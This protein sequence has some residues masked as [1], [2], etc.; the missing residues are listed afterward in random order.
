MKSRIGLLNLILWKQYLHKHRLWLLMV[1]LAAFALRIWNM[2]M[3]ENELTGILIG[4]Y[5][6]DEAGARL[7]AGLQE[8]KAQGKTVG[9]VFRFLDYSDQ[10]TMLRDI[11]NGTLEC[12]YVLPKGFFENI[13]DGKIRKQ[14]KLYHAESSGAHK[15][16]YEVV[17]SH[18]FGMLSEE[19]LQGWLAECSLGEETDYEQKLLKWKTD[20]E[21][22]DATFSF[23]F[24]HVGRKQEAQEAVLDI[25]RGL[26]GI[27]IFFLGLLGL[28]NCCEIS[29]KVNAFGEYGMRVIESVSL[30]IAILG[31]VI[32]GG[33]FI[34]L[35]GGFEHL[36][37]ELWGLTVYFVIL[38]IYFWIC[39]Q[40]LRKPGIIYGAIPILV[41]GSILFCPIFF[42]VETWIPALGYLGKLFPVYWYLNLFI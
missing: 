40:I 6:E 15:L 4:V 18:L 32:T 10:E 39:K 36:G 5:T 27:M 7:L 12:A 42:S 23:V 19:V 29:E 30:H 3:T 13:S 35:S 16:S 38:E 33:L 41:L 1:L 9:D 11:K 28:A 17:F 26:T 22:G 2:K 34:I 37:K 14:I 21:N 8:P 20:Y 25:T 31:S 24:E